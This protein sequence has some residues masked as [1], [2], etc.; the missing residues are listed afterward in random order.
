MRSAKAVVQVSVTTVLRWAGVGVGGD[1]VRMWT[2]TMC[3]VW[4]Q[5]VSG[6]TTGG[7]HIDSGHK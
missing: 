5:V 6:D 1:E 2:G 3:D 4:G 7:P